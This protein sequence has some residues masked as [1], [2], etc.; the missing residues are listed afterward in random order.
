[1]SF[2]SAPRGDALEFS[3]SQGHPSSAWRWQAPEGQRGPKKVSRVGKHLSEEWTE[4]R[5]GVGRTLNWEGGW[6]DGWSE[7]YLE[8]QT[9]GQATAGHPTEGAYLPRLEWPFPAPHQVC[10]W[11]TAAQFRANR[12]PPS[13]EAP[14]LSASS[15]GQAPL[16]PWDAPLPVG[17]P[18]VTEDRGRGG[19]TRQGT[20]AAGA[21]SITVP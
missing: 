11:P 21:L 10:K 14:F 12:T 9:A 2:P 8:G 6:T 20:R 3:S 4:G 16:F 19:N 17:Y 13:G 18:Q 1:M 15:L 5:T 7:G